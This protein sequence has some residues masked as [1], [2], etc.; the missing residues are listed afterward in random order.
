MLIFSQFIQKTEI[1]FVFYKKHKLVCFFKNFIL[2][3][4]K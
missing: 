1:L 4:K 2:H 3:K